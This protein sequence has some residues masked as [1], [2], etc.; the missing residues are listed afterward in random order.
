MFTSVILSL[1]TFIKMAFGK[2]R[3]E[4]ILSLGAAIKMAFCKC[5]NEVLLEPSKI[6]LLHIV[7]NSI[8]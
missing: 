5:S 4:V 3:Y 6:H 1:N 7:L 2:C 8:M